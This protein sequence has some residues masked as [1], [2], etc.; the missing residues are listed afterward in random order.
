MSKYHAVI[1]LEAEDENATDTIFIASVIISD[2]T[3]ETRYQKKKEQHGIHMLRMTMRAAYHPITRL[4]CL[5]CR[6]F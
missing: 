4:F 6:T 2:G 3:L 1:T 5:R